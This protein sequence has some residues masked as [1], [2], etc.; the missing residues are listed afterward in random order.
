MISA[1]IKTSGT[2][3]VNIGNYITGNWGDVGGASVRYYLLMKP[4]RKFEVGALRDVHPE[5]AAKSD[6]DLKQCSNPN[7]AG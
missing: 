1:P 5:P 6:R 3:Q 4:I 2:E 7:R